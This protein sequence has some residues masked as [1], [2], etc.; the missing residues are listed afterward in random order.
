MAIHPLGEI[1]WENGPKDQE[2]IKNSLNLL[3]KIGPTFWCGYSYAWEGNLK[4]RAKDGEGARIALYDFATAFC[5]TNSFHLNGDQTKS[6]KSSMTYRPFTLEGNFAFA[7]GVQE[8][9]IQSYDGF[10]EV[11]PAIPESW[12]ELSFSNLRTE[13]AFLVSAKR[14]SGQ[15]N[16]IEI[17]A[18]KGGKC[19][20]K[21]PFKTNYI[22]Q[23][24]GVK[25]ISQDQ[26]YMVLEFV[27]NGKVIIKN[28]YE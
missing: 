26:D 2:I 17:K 4:A 9:L 16:E 11:F 15:V 5:S 14:D 3:D 21:L 13:G 18:E 28:G 12:K 20:V 6:G 8:M 25:I 1:R 19:K 24:N 7:A 23:K 27:K 22:P 10:I